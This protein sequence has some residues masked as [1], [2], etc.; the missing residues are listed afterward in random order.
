MLKILVLDDDADNCA[1]L[2]HIIRFAGYSVQSTTQSDEFSQILLGW[3]PDIV[4]IDLLLDSTD[5]ISVLSNLP[6]LTSPPSIIILSGAHSRLLEAATRSAKAHG[7]HVLGCLSKPFNPAALRGLIVRYQAESEK[8]NQP[9]KHAVQHDI[10][11]ALLEHAIDQQFFYLVYQP[12]L[13]CKT[14]SLSGF[15]ALCRL[16]LPELGDISPE[17]FIPLC[18]QAGLINRLTKLIIDQAVKWFANFVHTTSLTLDLPPKNPKLALN[19]SA[20]SLSSNDIFDY[21]IAQCQHY[22]IAP[23]AIILELTETAAMSDSISSL[24]ILTRLR[25][26]GFE[27]S[28]DDFGVGYSSVQQLVRLP[29]SELKIDKQFVMSAAESRE[30]RLVISSLIEM[31]HTLG[32]S[33]TAEGIEDSQTLSFLQKKHCDT[34]QGFYIAR[35]M[36]PEQI[37]SWANGYQDNI[38]LARLRTL[39]ALDILDTAAEER[40]NRI[41]RLAQRIFNV[42]VCTFSLIDEHR[43]WYKAKIGLKLEQIEREGSLCQLAMQKSGGMIVEDTMLNAETR[44]NAMVAGEPYARFYAGQ[45]VAAPNGVVIGSLCLLGFSSREMSSSDRHALQA[46]AS[47][48]EDELNI[49]NRVTLDPLTRLKN[50]SSFELR[51]KSLLTLCQS[52]QLSLNVIHIRTPIAQHSTVENFDLVHDRVLR[53]CAK[54]I[55]TIFS[56]ADLIARIDAESFIIVYVQQH[57]ELIELAVESF[58]QLWLSQNNSKAFVLNLQLDRLN[59]TDQNISNLQQFYVALDIQHCQPIVL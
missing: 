48:L 41:L 33:V 40:Y 3:C 11:P 18:E 10:T 36:R 9:N 30:S 50:R 46:L 13:D 55:K 8:K 20:A 14:T 16:Q 19:I 44:D 39:R 54:L 6:E 34:V 31:A 5:A 28:I 45:P 1:T 32:M 57:S 47:M 26:M 29:F 25:L 35:P 43:I 4:V 15:E 37:K 23:S 49:V 38:E 12:K 59:M 53:D 56:G 52:H 27:L 58:E 17:V 24:D 2:E 51:A 42:P 21:L 7:Y 22:Q